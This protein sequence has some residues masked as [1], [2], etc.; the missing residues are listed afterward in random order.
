MIKPNNKNRKTSIAG[1]KTKV[2]VMIIVLAGLVSTYIGWN[3]AVQEAKTNLQKQFDFQAHE[4]QNQIQARLKVYA[5]LLHSGRGL[6]LAS[7]KV[8]RSDFKAF[9]NTLNIQ[10]LYPGIQGLGF[11]V[12]VPAADK[13]KHIAAIQKEGFPDYEIRPE[14]ARAVFYTTIIYLEPFEKRNLR[15]FGYDMYTESVRREAMSRAA[16]LNEITLSGKVKLV[17]ET[18]KDVQAGFLMFLPL[19][20]KNQDIN[21]VEQRRANL[22][23]WVYA[24]FRVND[25]INGILGDFKQAEME[26]G[27][28]DALPV[29]DATKLFSS[30]VHNPN[31]AGLFNTVKTISFAG[32]SWIVRLHSNPKFEQQLNLE[33]AY[34]IAW[35]G[36]GGSL[37]LGIILWLLA[38]SRAKAW[39]L[40]NS[41]NK[42]LIKTNTELLYYFEQPFVGMFTSDA[43]QNFI[44]VN[45]R[46]CDILGYSRE[47]L[48][49]TAKHWRFFT[50]PEDQGITPL[51]FEQVKQKLI[52]GYQIDKRWLHKS[53]ETLY[54][55]IAVK[56]LRDNQGE[57]EFFIGMVLD[58]TER[59]L[60]ENELYQAKEAAL[61]ASQFKSD[62]LANMSHEIRTPMNAIIGMSH[63]LMNSDLN[64]RQ[65]NFM[66]KIQLSSHHLLGIINDI[67]DFSKIEAGKLTVESTEFDVEK[68]VENVITLMLEKASAKS[69]ELIAEIDSAVPD[70][71][72]GDSMRIGQILI[73]YATNAIKFTERG[74]VAIEVKIKQDCG[75]NLLLYLA[76]RDT[77]IGLS[78]E[79]QGLLFQS[80]Q[81]ADSST[82]RKY[83]G[84]GLGLAISKKLA[85]LMGGEVGVVSEYGKGATF[86]FTARLGKSDK[87]KPQLLLK[88]D[89]SGRKV[90]VVEDN[91]DT[92]EALCKLLEKMSFQTDS[93]AIGLVALAKLKQAAGQ[94]QPYEL[95]LLDWQ[96]PGMNGLEAAR[97]IKTLKL[98]PPPHL[99]MVTAFSRDDIMAEAKIAGI[100]EVLV[101]PVNSSLL[102]DALNRLLTGNDSPKA[103]VPVLPLSVFEHLKPI[104]G[105]RVLLVED[106]ELNQ[107]VA[108]EL[109]KEA[110]LS[111][112]VAGDGFV[113]LQ[114]VEKKQYDI[115]L[116][117]MQMPVMD[118]IAATRAIREF[119]ELADLPIVAMTAN[120][121]QSD[122][123]ACLAAGMNDH[124]GKPI[125]PDEL[126]DTLLRWVKPRLTE[127]NQTQ[128]TVAQASYPADE[129]RLKML[130]NIQGL[131][132]TAGLRRALGKP[133]MYLSLLRKFVANQKTIPE[134]LN[135]A[136]SSN[137]LELAERLAHTLKGLAG[138]I[139]AELLQQNAG[140]VEAAIHA[141]Q[142]P[143]ATE[144]QPLL[145]TL[146]TNLHSLIAQI[147]PILAQPET[148]EPETAA[149]IDLDAL[150][151]VSR[152]LASLLEE[153]NSEAV[154]LVNANQSAL[155]AAMLETYQEF[156]TSIETFDFEPAV[157]ILKQTAA[158][159]QINF[160]TTEQVHDNQA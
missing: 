83:G 19:Y 121:M 76:V 105:A 72:I 143:I 120:A 17:Q 92:R 56:V 9:V 110:G 151:K 158:I 23:G 7:D 142:V 81:Q 12:V 103:P 30:H 118:G 137:Q 27:I 26:L 53:G 39:R 87:Q 119:E 85:E 43:K 55:H 47:D 54:V 134:Q 28:Y 20:R 15:A 127:N 79:Q 84:T 138:N 38:T 73:N 115:V 4:I 116:M 57:I 97:Q 82:A 52:D 42:E 59:K 96:M 139:G 114:M 94:N 147:E 1:L 78:E 5:Q 29:S 86:W 130:V 66:K 69:L 34:F 90:L 32:H 148:I 65:Q 136:L 95:V 91:N 98:N 74:K 106:N 135:L 75:D 36:S 157:A 70:Y 155:K 68:A 60:L 149:Q 156:Y 8:T 153:G 99:I 128:V 122:R 64:G 125:E 109:L 154:D 48:L 160:E 11:S 71:L 67:L 145:Q 33:R 132:T 2:L 3:I 13:A 107:E 131:D 133:A 62:F 141:Q 51:Y 80:F 129:A 93:A 41:L 152:Q 108:V 49:S 111:I 14:G 101:K 22:L 126:W 16:D 46:L 21:T 40:A 45:Q 25:F 124:L 24:P 112:D 150:A 10:E 102:F 88:P 104:R 144:L 31:I 159:Y 50:H 63:L 18:N 100:E 89:L 35:L 58:I 140:A 37:M 117:D 146:A 6:F 44:N 61:T 77:G 123:E 113:A